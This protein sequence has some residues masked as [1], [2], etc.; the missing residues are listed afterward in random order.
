M[1]APIAMP[2]TPSERAHLAVGSEGVLGLPGPFF[3]HWQVQW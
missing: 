1:P 3:D 2:S